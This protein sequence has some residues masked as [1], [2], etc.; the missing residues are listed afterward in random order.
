MRNNQLYAG[1][2]WMLSG[3][4]CVEEIMISK[5]NLLPPYWQDVATVLAEL[6]QQ[7]GRTLPTVWQ[8]FANAMAKN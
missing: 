8:K 6:C 7:C 3:G 1:G 4:V 5:R 2:I